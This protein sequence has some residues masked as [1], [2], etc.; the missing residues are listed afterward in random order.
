MVSGKA[1]FHQGIVQGLQ[2]EVIDRK[3][4]FT[5]QQDGFPTQ[6]LGIKRP[7]P[8]IGIYLSR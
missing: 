6:E 8:Q 3:R 5:K 2:S 1:S 4:I 7:P